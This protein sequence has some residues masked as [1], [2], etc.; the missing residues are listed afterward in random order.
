MY[1]LYSW[2]MSW[3]ET[4]CSLFSPTS[5]DDAS[6]DQALSSRVAALNATDLGLAHLGVEVGPVSSEV[7]SVVNACGES[8]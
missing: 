5:A 6:H 1:A 3:A 2:F 7:D 4:S 8:K